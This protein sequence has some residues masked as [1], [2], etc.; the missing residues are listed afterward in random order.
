MVKT[1]TAQIKTLSQLSDKIQI[2][3]LE[4]SR[5]G[6]KKNKI[7]ISLGIGAHSFQITLT[8]K[9]RFVL[10]MIIPD[11]FANYQRVVLCPARN[12]DKSVSSTLLV[13]IL[14]MIHKIRNNTYI[15]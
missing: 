8:K 1:V 2:R 15:I 9:R 11:L 12:K 14:T 10:F 5:E 4:V 7:I 13:I 6:T 3:W